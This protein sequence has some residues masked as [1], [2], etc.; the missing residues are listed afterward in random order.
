MKSI[1]SGRSAPAIV[2]SVIALCF[3]VAG[4][5][6]AGSLITSKQIKNGTI[7][8]T[9]ISSKA[10]KSLKGSAGPAGAAGAR[11]DTGA[12]GPSHAFSASKAASVNVTATSTVV[13]SLDLP[14]GSYV[15]TAKARM[16]N[17]DAVN[18]VMGNCSLAA[19]SDSDS[20]QFGI[21]TSST[22][23]IA[24]TE[25][26]TVAHTFDAPGTINWTCN[27]SGGAGTSFAAGDRRITAIQVESLTNTTLP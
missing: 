21:D 5:A 10:K 24:H 11:G 6:V 7:Q 3:A 27:K 15:I 12:R 16:F 9:D 18:P 23:F 1:L 4:S 14:A 13:A 2:I 20:I 26:S 19:G 22:L 17:G 8:L 25:V